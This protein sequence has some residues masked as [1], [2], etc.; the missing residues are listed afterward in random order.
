[1][2]KSYII[3]YIILMVN[4]IVLIVGMTLLSVLILRNS[5]EAGVNE[6][7]INMDLEELLD[8]ITVEAVEVDGEFK[9]NASVTLR[10][11]GEEFDYYFEVED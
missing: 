9:E 2:K 8:T 3:L 4:L 10:V 11:M 6:V 5:K 7:R 1:M